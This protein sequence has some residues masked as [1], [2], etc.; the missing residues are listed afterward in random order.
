VLPGP[1][2]GRFTLYEDDG[3]SW[4]FEDGGYRT[5]RFEAVQL[6]GAEGIR[7]TR[8]VLHDGFQVPGRQLTVRV[9]GRQEPPRLVTLDGRDI[10]SWEYDAER[11]VLSV[12]FEEQRVRQ[13]LRVR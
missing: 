9:F 1:E 5:T 4:D 10:P 8:R 11:E 6:P 12:R 2:P 13:E 7:F 3:L